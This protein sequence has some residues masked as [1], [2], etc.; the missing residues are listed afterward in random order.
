MYFVCCSRQDQDSDRRGT[1]LA[2]L[3]VQGLVE[4]V[5]A[6]RQSGT[7]T[8]YFISGLLGQA[9]PQAEK[10]LLFLC[11]FDTQKI[12]E[13]LFCR[14][15][16]TRKCWGPNGHI[17]HVTYP[18]LHIPANLLIDEVQFKH[19]IQC[20][21][22]FGFV[23]SRKGALG[24]REFS[25]NAAIRECVME[26]NQDRDYLQWTCRIVICHAFPGTREE[27]GLVF[28]PKVLGELC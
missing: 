15:R 25:I 6:S 28:H 8:P 23:E 24:K 16:N 20:L 13:I 14:L 9:S 11:T 12:P 17:E 1:S 19:C 26:A 5:S 7:L 3:L 10:L 4:L 2:Q 22:S 27:I 21:E 18:V